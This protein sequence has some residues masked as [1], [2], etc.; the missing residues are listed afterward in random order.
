M[1]CT[2][3]LLICLFPITLLSGQPR[4]DT[5]LHNILMRSDKSIVQQVIRQPDTFRLQIIYTQIDRDRNNRPSFHNYYYNFDNTLYFNPASTVKLPLA[6]LSLEKL[7]RIG[8]KDITKYTRVQ[9]DSS[10]AGQVAMLFDSTSEDYLPTIAHFIKKAFLVSDNDA[11]NRM[12]QFVGQ[13]P[14]NA[15]LKDKRYH[16]TR[17]TRQFMG[18]NEEQN[19]RSNQ[20]RF[21][22]KSGDVI[23]TQS[24]AYNDAVHDFGRVIKI[25]RAHLNSQD[26]LVN[27][28][29]D[30]THANVVGLEDLQRMLQTALFPESVPAR[31][32]FHLSE[33][34]Y[35]FL[36]RY[37]SQYPSETSYPK[38]DTSQYFDSYVKF[39]FRHGSHRMPTHVRVFNKVGWAYGFM[40]D[41]SYVVDFSNKIEFML[42]ATLYVNS[43]GVL[44]DNRYEYKETG[45][46]FL[47]DVGQVVYQYELKRRRKVVPDLKRFQ[48]RYEKRDPD[49]KRKIIKDVDN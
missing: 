16:H 8:R 44:N 5:L 45:W 17:I 1:R 37:L 47:Y 6:F 36:Y 43:D 35:A 46:P 2:C 23:Y 13:G 33:D 41:V 32:R 39:F 24:P 19:R 27:A 20:V 12:Y 34:D 30:F 38:Y 26:S 31:E 15:W 4:T 7:N 42:T 18:F 29:I 25:G 22:D 21:L 48:I 40:T 28:P 14:L 9:F 10:Y 3:L 49:D 11:Y